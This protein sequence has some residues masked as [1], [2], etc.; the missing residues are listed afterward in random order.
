MTMI[1]ETHQPAAP[2][3]T[4]RA[5]AIGAAIGVVLAFVVVGGALLL[6]GQGTSAALAVGGM[7]ALWG[8]LGFG[9][10]FGGVR[11]LTQHEDD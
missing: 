11:H 10:M 6:T 7:A 4:L 9:S 2:P 3:G 8:G 5:V 1:G